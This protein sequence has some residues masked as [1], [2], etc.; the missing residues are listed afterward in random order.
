MVAIAYRSA[1]SH[2]ILVT[3]SIELSGLADGTYPGHAQIPFKQIKKGNR[4]TI[5]GTDTLAGSCISLDECVR[6]LMKWA[7]IKVEAAVMCV[8]E[9]AADAMGLEDRGRLDVGKR[10]D[11]VILREDGTVKETWVLGKRI[12]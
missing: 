8:T 12:V 10:A 1:P 11:F 7:S 5:E 6:N 2:C 3:D 9:N 4:V